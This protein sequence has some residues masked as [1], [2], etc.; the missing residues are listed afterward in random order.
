MYQTLSRGEM[1]RECRRMMKHF[2]SDDDYWG[3]YDNY[4]KCVQALTPFDRDK[5]IAIL[6]YLMGQYKLQIDEW[7]YLHGGRYLQRE[8]F[9]DT[10][11]SDQ[12]VS[13]LLYIEKHIPAFALIREGKTEE[14]EYLMEWYESQLCINENIPQK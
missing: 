1:D 6:K 14:A 8:D 2:R 13:D 10:A 9:Y 7:A 11:E 4:N 3:D 5:S 12:I